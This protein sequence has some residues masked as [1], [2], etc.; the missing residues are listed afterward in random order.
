MKL[1]GRAAVLGAI[2]ALGVG[3]SP[4]ETQRLTPSAETELCRGERVTAIVTREARRAVLGRPQE[5]ADA[6]NGILGRLQPVTPSRV[7]RNFLLLGTGD[8]C[9]ETARQDSERI[10]RAQPFIS[11]AVIRVQPVGRDSVRL[12][13]E[14]IDEYTIRA[15]AW[16]LKGVPVGVE[17]GTINLIG[18][19]REVL[20]TGEIGRGG[21]LGFGAKFNDYQLFGQPLRFSIGAASR[22]LVSYSNVQLQRPFLTDL[23]PYAWLVRA[24][25][26]RYY[27]T[28]HEPSIRDVSLEFDARSWAIGGLRRWPSNSRGFQAGAVVT[29]T[30]S[31]PIRAVVIRENG[32]EPTSAPLL[33]DRYT[34]FGAVRVGVGGGYRNIRYFKV[35]GLGYLSAVADV[36]TGW[37]ATAMLLQGIGVFPGMPPD[38]IGVWSSWAGAGNPVVQFGIGAEVEAR[39][40]GT[41]GA[42]VSTLGSAGFTLTAKSSPAHTA[43]LDFQVAGGAN[44]RVPMQLTLRDDDGLL[45]YRSSDVGGGHRMIWRVEDRWL[46]PSPFARAEFAVAALAQAG[47]LFAGDALYGVTTPWRYGA[48]FAAIGALPRGSKHTVRLEF[49]WPINPA[50]ARQMEFRFGYG[51]RGA[52]YGGIPGALLGAREAESATRAISPW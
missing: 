34:S 27:Y 14:T 23:Q 51:D 12:L 30:Y 11:D 24:A 4:A 5:V 46:I 8:I 39:W 38:R 32:P 13:V 42:H 33:T 6:V 41:P 10:L 48:G 18:G 50:G 1:P 7:V 16:G 35:P 15:E 25:Q 17:V 26:A 40:P 31:D 43:L 19:A 9:N 3:A 21:A 52:G 36:G 45:G 37:Q 29:G 49:G 20:F 47:R 44:S 22:P 28:F 2:A